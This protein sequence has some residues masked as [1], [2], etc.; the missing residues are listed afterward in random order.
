VPSVWWLAN[1]RYLMGCLAPIRRALDIAQT[2]SETA[3]ADDPDPAEVADARQRLIDSGAGEPPLD[4]LSKLFGL[5]GFEQ[6]VL[7]LCAGVELDSRFSRL[8]AGLGARDGPSFALA[9]SLLPEADWSALVPERPLRHRRLVRVGEAPTLSHAPLRIEERVLHYLT[10]FETLDPR[11][12]GVLRPVD[13]ASGGDLVPAHMDIARR[14]VSAWS[15]ATAASE[16]PVLQLRGHDLRRKLP[17]AAAVCAQLGRRLLHL[18]PQNVPSTR[19][20]LEE[21]LSLWGRDATLGKLGLLVDLHDESAQDPTRGAA[22]ATLIGAAEGLVLVAVPDGLPGGER[23]QI[24][25]DVGRPPLGQQR[26]QWRA[27]LGEVA[28]RLDDQIEGL[29][30]QFDLSAPRI[31]AA[32]L[33]CRGRLLPP[34]ADRASLQRLPVDQ[35]GA[36]LWDSARSQARPHIDDVAQRVTPVATWQ[37]LVV[38]EQV[39]DTLRQIAAQARHR[40]RVLEEWG[41]AAQGDHGLGVGALF[42]GPS[43][44]GKT[45][46]AEVL[47]ADLRLDLYR[48]DLSVTVSKWL[49]ETEKNLRRIFD[50]ADD[51][52]ALLLFD[53]ADALFGKRTAVKDAHDRYANVGVSY[54]L[55]R[56][57]QY[58]GLAILTTNREDDLDQAFVRRL[59]FIVRFAFPNAALRLAIWSKVFPAAAPLEHVDP[60]K[61]ARLNL[62]GGNIRNIAINAAFLAADEGSPVQM[63]HV[64][65]A[66]RSEYTK[67]RQTLV[68][69]DVRDW[70]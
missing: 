63:A 45:L 16:S 64:L 56:L 65:R 50:A 28:D 52:G 13:P 26:E 34:T 27:V 41:F 68:E 58:R 3:D 47:A 40:R 60:A 54:L 7:L 51:G 70:V 44:T 43:G 66:T 49:G 32:W 31:E 59:R 53:E 46:A 19:A 9:L 39:E 20:E 36:A 14:L 48:V 22:A 24:A 17:V 30:G 57:E 33:D 23:H 2:G 55:Q 25:V 42:A 69:Q 29:V 12:A 6:A 38:P 11:L 21:F 4:T 1:Q 15:Q 8:C 62:A 10:G 61:L 35:I 18:Q 37:S 67:L 5:T